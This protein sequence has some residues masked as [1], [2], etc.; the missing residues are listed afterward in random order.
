MPIT[1][2]A[3]GAFSGAPDAPGLGEHAEDFRVAL[4]S[5]GTFELSE[6]RAAGPVLLMFYRGFW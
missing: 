4:A 1:T 2:N 5:G 6:A 3:Y